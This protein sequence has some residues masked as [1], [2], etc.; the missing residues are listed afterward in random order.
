M[1]NY[2]KLVRDVEPRDLS[3]ADI[4]G[5]SVGVVSSLLTLGGLGISLCAW[6]YP[7]SPAGRLG[8]AIHHRLLL[9]GG[10]ASGG[11]AHGIE[12]ARGGAAQGG[13]IGGVSRVLASDSSNSSNR[14]S[15]QKGLQPGMA[16]GTFA[17]G[18]ATGGVATGREATGGNAQGGNVSF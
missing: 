15:G 5:I 18:N 17:G 16:H 12:T 4:T 13:D 6:K 9:R 3:P 2:R 10:D 14:G 8:T 11:D 1:I 7:S